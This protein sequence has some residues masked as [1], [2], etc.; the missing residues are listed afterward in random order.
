MIAEVNQGGA[1]MQ[2]LLAQ[3]GTP[4][5]VR[6]VRAMR[7][8]SQ[9]AEPVAAAY[10]HGEVRHAAEFPLL[11]EQMCGC[12]P[13]HRQVPS[14]GRTDAL[15]WVVNALLGGLDTGSRELVL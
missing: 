6:G 8:K 2:S 5:P 4:L 12:V 1:L 3:A 15:V 9:R 11:E 14:P 7:G 10:D 13:C